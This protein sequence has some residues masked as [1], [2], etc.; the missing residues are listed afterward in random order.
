MAVTFLKAVVKIVCLAVPNKISD[1]LT[2]LLDILFHYQT[3]RYNKYPE[4]GG[5]Q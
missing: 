3:F 2:T 1:C 5:L 4:V